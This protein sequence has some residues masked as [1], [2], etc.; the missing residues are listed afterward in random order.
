MQELLLLDQCLCDFGQGSLVH[1]DLL[2][3]NNELDRFPIL[4]FSREDILDGE[5][6]AVTFKECFITNFHLLFP[7]L[8]A[9][10]DLM[11]SLL[12][13]IVDISVIVFVHPL[14][15]KANIIY[16]CLNFEPILAD[17]VWVVFIKDERAG[18]FDHLYCVS[19]RSN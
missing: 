2:A 7:V 4:L 14:E 15:L 10:F 12:D 8:A 9:F 3:D 1:F 17:L 16:V 19:H 18:G 13:E 6:L 11:S 5:R